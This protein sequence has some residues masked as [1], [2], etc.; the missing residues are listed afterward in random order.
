M[1]D[2]RPRAEKVVVWSSSPGSEKPHSQG[3]QGGLSS[4]DLWERAADL[5]VSAGSAWETPACTRLLRQ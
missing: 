3:L 1:V 2:G 5:N 4:S